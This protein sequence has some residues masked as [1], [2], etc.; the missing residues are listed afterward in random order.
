MLAQVKQ[1]CHRLPANWL[2]D[3]GFVTFQAIRTASQQGVCIY[4][5]V[6]APKDEARDRYVP[7][8]DDPPAIAAWRERMG[9]DEAKALYKQRAASV[10]CINA[11]ARSHRGIQ[12]VRVRGQA[13]VK[14]VALWT[15]ITHNLLIWIRHLK[16]SQ[17]T[18]TG[19]RPAAV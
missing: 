8:P 12:Q 4:A 1:R 14:C 2:I 6:P 7:L 5:P 9:T 15:A 16:P 17:V 11:Q 19:P 18:Q 3:G 13:K 10:E